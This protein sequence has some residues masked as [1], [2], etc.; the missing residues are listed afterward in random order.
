[1]FLHLSVILL[2]GGV[3]TSGSGG[4][5]SLW[6]GAGGVSLWV[7]GVSASGSGVYTPVDTHMPPQHTF[8][9]THTT[10]VEMAIEAG[11]THPN[12]MHSCWKM[13]SNTCT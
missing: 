10:P 6:V 7:R 8:P 5:V 12:G 2:T 1:M 11:G 9:R 4:G 3:S 13:Y